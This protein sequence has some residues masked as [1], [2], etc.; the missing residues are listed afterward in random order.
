MTEIL[1]D[2]SRIACGVYETVDRPSVCP[3]V[4]PV[5]RQQQRRAVGLLLSAVRAGNDRQQRAPALSSNG[6]AERRS[7]AYAGSVVLTAEVRG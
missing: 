5:D 2:T 6:T 4:C 1:T 3:S 7:A